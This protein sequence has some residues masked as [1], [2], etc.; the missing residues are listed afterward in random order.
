MPPAEVRRAARQEP[1][2]HG[3]EGGGVGGMGGLYGKEKEANHDGSLI[4]DTSAVPHLNLPLICRVG[5]RSADKLRGV[6]PPMSSSHS[7]TDC[8]SS[9]HFFFHCSRP[10]VEARSLGARGP[11]INQAKQQAELCL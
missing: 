11:N 7:H 4:S 6:W 10:A 3:K 5:R 2:H 1:M 9:S 8:S